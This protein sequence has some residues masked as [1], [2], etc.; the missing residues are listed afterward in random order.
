MIGVQWFEL[1]SI[2]K[3]SQQVQSH[4]VVTDGEVPN[5]LDHTT[6]DPQ[7]VGGPEHWASPDIQVPGKA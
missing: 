1:A 2:V 6:L 5:A 4:E 3:S 7:V